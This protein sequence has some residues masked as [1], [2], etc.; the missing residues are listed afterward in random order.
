MPLDRGLRTG[1][2]HGTR[3]RAARPRAEAFAEGDGEFI[4]LARVIRNRRS[5]R[6][7]RILAMPKSQGWRIAPASGS[8]ASMKE[9]TDQICSS[10]KT[11]V[12]AGNCRI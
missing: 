12:Y 6:H 2:K 9:T 11:S 10:L 5:G 1:V 8:P 3:F 7:R 4:A